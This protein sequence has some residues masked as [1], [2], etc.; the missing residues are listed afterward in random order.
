[1]TDPL[2]SLSWY[3]AQE[4]AISAERLATYCRAIAGE[5]RRSDPRKVGYRTASALKLEL[6]ILSHRAEALARI[7]DSGVIAPDL[8]K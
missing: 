8:P 4:A 1:M 5:I 2:A 3:A 7:L 6:E